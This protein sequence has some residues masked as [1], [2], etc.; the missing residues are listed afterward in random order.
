MKA[1]RGNPKAE[2]EGIVDILLKVSQLAVDPGDFISGI[3]I[4]PLMVLGEGER[5]KAAD[6][7]IMSK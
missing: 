3:D 1:F 6:A 2:I 7:L 5:V 4:N